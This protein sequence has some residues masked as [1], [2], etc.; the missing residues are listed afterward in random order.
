MNKVGIILDLLID[1]FG[2]SLVKACIILH[3]LLS[4]Q[5][6]PLLDEYL[7]VLFCK[8]HFLNLLLDLIKA[9]LSITKAKAEIIE[10]IRVVVF[11][12]HREEG[13]LI[14]VK[15]AILCVFLAMDYFDH[16]WYIF[17]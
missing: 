17:P 6:K 7:E 14:V 2:Q 15:Y 10:A 4:S 3:N 8:V 9:S 16:V 1:F 11:V 12:V 5:R 13:Y